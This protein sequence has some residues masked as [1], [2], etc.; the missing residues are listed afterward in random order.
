[1]SQQRNKSWEYL[2]NDQDGRVTY[3]NSST[4]L[5]KHIQ[6]HVTNRS[7]RLNIKRTKLQYR[8]PIFS[9]LAE[10]SLKESRLDTLGNAAEQIITVFYE[11]ITIAIRIG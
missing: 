10:P 3:K 6:P 5:L 1:M 9:P 11:V 8:Q 7:T 2:M 4:H